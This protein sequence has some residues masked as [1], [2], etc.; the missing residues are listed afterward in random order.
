MSTKNSIILKMF[1]L[2][3]VAMSLT[4]ANITLAQTSEKNYPKPNKSDKILFYIQ[5]SM[6][7]NTI[8]YELNIDKFGKLNSE[9]PVHPYWIRYEENGEIQEL[10]YIQKKLAYG[11]D[12]KL[13]NNKYQIYNLTL[14]SYPSQV[15]VLKKLSENS[16]TRAYTTVNGK[17]IELQKIFFETEGENLLSPTVKYIDISGIEVKTGKYI[18]EKIKP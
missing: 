11:I 2:I 6:N 12:A 1:I 17:F 16:K 13:V 15:I 14:V 3:V 10:S 18:T 5:R 9:Y 4:I 8:V 7:L